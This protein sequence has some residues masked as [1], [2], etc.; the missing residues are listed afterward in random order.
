MLAPTL[1]Q[2]L[3]LAGKPVAAKCPALV[4]LVDGA[5][6]SEKYGAAV[7]QAGLCNG[8]GNGSGNS[9]GGSGGANGGDK[10][11]DKK[12]K[13]APPPAMSDIHV[14]PYTP[15]TTS[16]PLDPTDY[17]ALGLMSSLRMLF[18]AA[19][20]HAFPQVAQAP[21]DLAPALTLASITRCGN[22]AFG[23]FQCNNAMGLGKWFKTLGGFGGPVA[24]KDI[25]TALAGG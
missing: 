10:K 2:A 12:G 19:L 7:A 21:A 3:S 16:A 5:K 15:T 20:T 9:G 17:G 4:K 22:P 25:A 11:K 6:K 13:D 24:P 14:T 23:D 1:D 18:T 8:S